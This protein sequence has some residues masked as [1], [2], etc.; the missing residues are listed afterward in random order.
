M[1]E[2]KELTV[3]GEP[4]GNVSI[5]S[6]IEKFELAQRVA[7]VFASSDMV[8]VHYRK[9]PSNVLI[10][11]NMAERMGLDPF[12]VMGKTYI[13]KGKIGIE[14]T[15]AIALINSSGKFEPLQ[16]KFNEAKTECFAHA[17]FVQTGEVYEGSTVSLQMAKDEGWGSK[18]RTLPELMLQYRSAVFFAR[19]YCPEA[20]MGLYTRDELVDIDSSRSAKKATHETPDTEEPDVPEA[21]IERDETA[22]GERESW[23]EFCHRNRL[24]ESK[25]NKLESYIAESAKSLGMDVQALKSNAVEAGDLDDMLEAVMS[26]KKDEPASE[27]AKGNWWDSTKHWSFRSNNVLKELILFGFGGEAGDSKV[28]A[29]NPAAYNILRTALPETKKV[30]VKKFDKMF[31][32]GAFN[33]LIGK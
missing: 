7:A 26:G 28:C 16:Y 12:M 15:L 24:S 5:F 1:E 19:V 9:K 11:M 29:D 3:V 21:V 25:I 30:L 31:G 33:E 8:P 13:I 27:P 17:K 32:V 6:T 22:A 23:E 20:I 10:A 18:W 4:A 2:S 14:A